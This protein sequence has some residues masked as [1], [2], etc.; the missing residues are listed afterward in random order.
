M[1]RGKTDGSDAKWDGSGRLTG[2]GHWV[3][4]P[5]AFREDPVEPLG[6]SWR[7][8]VLPSGDAVRP[9]PYPAYGSPGWRAELEAVQEA[10]AGRTLEQTRI[11]GYWASKGPFRA[12]TDFAKE[13][14]RSEER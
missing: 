12:F 11:V 13:L 10:V 2:P 6:G 8:W 1:A 14:I 9:A 3:P 4:T 7:P 5:P